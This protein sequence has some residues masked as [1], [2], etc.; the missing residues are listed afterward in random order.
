MRENVPG[1]SSAAS[2]KYE[3][4][5]KRRRKRRKRKEGKREA[6]TECYFTI[7]IT[8]QKCIQVLQSKAVHGLE[9]RR[10]KG[11]QVG[12]I[13]RDLRMAF[14]FWCWAEISFPTCMFFSLRSLLFN[15]FYFLSSFNFLFSFSLLSFRFTITNEY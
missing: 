4:G 2:L 3:M 9:E 8:L 6:I 13:W 11:L 1:A 12:L 14:F 15:S 10:W 7:L 5:D